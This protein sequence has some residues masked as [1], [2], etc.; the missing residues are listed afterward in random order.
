[1]ANSSNIDMSTFVSG[2]QGNH[3][4]KIDAP[5]VFGT[6]NYFGAS[7]ASLGDFNQDGIDDIAIGTNCPKIVSTNKQ[8]LL[9]FVTS[10]N[11][12]FYLFVVL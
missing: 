11:Y 2:H 3:M 1:M 4:L 12:S 9:I 6:G 10:A 5:T 7:M 8:I